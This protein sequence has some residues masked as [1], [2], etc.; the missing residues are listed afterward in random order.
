MFRWDGEKR[1]ARAEIEFPLAGKPQWQLQAGTDLRNENWALRNS[2]SGPAPL[3]G[4]M[5]LKR[6]V[7]FIR[8]NDVMSGGWRWFTSTELS[9]RDYHDVFAPGL[10]VPTLLR[11]GFQLKQ[12]FGVEASVFRYPERRLNVNGAALLS[13]ARLW[14]TP[15]QSYS[16]L[17]VS[18]DL[19]WLPQ[20]TGEKYEVNEQ[21]RVGRTSGTPPFDEL[22]ML[23]VLGDTDL[24]MRAHIATRDAKKGSAPLGRNYFLSNFSAL[25][26]VSPIAIAHIKV[27]PLLDTGKITDPLPQIGSHKWLWDAG[28]EAKLQAFGFTIT[29]SYARDLRS[30][31]NAYVATSP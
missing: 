31:R 30:G 14:S 10:L 23:G 24:Q 5:N 18:I 22:F 27:G 28:L 4:A 13:V 3:L 17:Q 26:D 2:F 9:N 25:R 19:R 15:N 7:G 11:P 16:Q 6:E 29:V 1:R 8:F 21:I 12:S 20:R